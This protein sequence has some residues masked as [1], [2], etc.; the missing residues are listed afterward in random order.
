MNRSVNS[1]PPFFVAWFNFAVTKQS[2]QSFNQNIK[3]ICHGSY[4]SSVKNIGMNDEC[5]NTN[6]APLDGN[7]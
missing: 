1:F 4:I 3:P 2:H 7:D 6:G 5:G